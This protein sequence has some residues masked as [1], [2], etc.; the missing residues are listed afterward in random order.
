M[1]R[2]GG[3]TNSH[4]KPIGPMHSAN[5]KGMPEGSNPLT[6]LSEELHRWRIRQL[7]EPLCHCVNSGDQRGVGLSDGASTIPTIDERVADM[8]A[9]A[10]AVGT[11]RMF[12]IGHCHG[13]PAAIVYTASHPDRVAGLVLMSTFANGKADIDHSGALSEED[14]ASWMEAVDH[15]GGG[16]CGLSVWAGESADPEGCAR[17]HQRR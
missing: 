10:D 4:V 8:A 13:G 5:L 6:A 7:A 12:V 11:K 1:Y 16:R 9:V 17:D 2:P 14:S 3:D 15:W